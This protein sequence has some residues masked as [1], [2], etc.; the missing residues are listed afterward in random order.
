M[1]SENFASNVF[2]KVDPIGKILTLP[3]G[4]Y[5]GN[6]SDFIVRGVMK[7]FPQNSHFHPQFIT[8]PTDKTDLERGAW[9]YILL[10][11][12]ARPEQITN[13]FAKF[14]SRQVNKNPDEQQ[15]A[16]LEKIT[17]I[18][19]YSNKLREIE[20]N[21]SISVIYTLVIAAVLL[22]SIAIIN[23]INLN[24]GMTAF[25]D[26]YL[27]ISKILGGTDGTPMRYFFYE[28]TIIGAI[29]IAVS[30]L[31]IKLADVT[32]IEKFGLHLLDGKWFILLTGLL[33]FL[34]IIVLSGFLLSLRRDLLTFRLRVKDQQAGPKKGISMSLIVVQN[35]ISICLIVSVIVIHRQTDYALEHSVGAGDNNLI[36]FQNVHSEVQSK[37]ETFKSELLKNTSIKS[38]SA[39]LDAPGGETNDMMSFTMEGYISPSNHT[40]ENTIGVLPCDYSFAEI[41]SLSF[42]SGQNFS[43]KNDDS[44]GSGEY[45]INESAMKKL[46]Y[47]N[48]HDIVG[49]D[50]SISFS[51]S[52]KIPKGKIIAVVKDFHLSSLKKKIEPLVF[53]K[54]KDLWLLNFL[55][56]FQTGAQ[57]QGLLD[58][59][60]VLREV[61]PDQP[62]QYNY[63]SHL[64]HDVYKTELL[65]ANLLALFTIAALFISVMGLLGLSL[66]T[67]QRRMREIAIR[68]VNGASI[69]SLIIMLSWGFIKWIIVAF[70]LA[71]P[72]S[73]YAMNKWLEPF[74]YKTSVSWWI[75]ALASCV[76][77]IIA[78]V[79]IFIQ[80]YKATTTSPIEVLRND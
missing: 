44:E 63:V 77:V 6:N 14:Y 47:T 1:I 62:M 21:S 15:T 20:I 37:F 29:S 53:F 50:F 11:P 73:L 48:P 79:A 30:L 3:S 17:D 70:V 38:V 8:T 58:V 9:I 45:I 71:I 49:K 32:V 68:K 7:D 33:I 25:S 34:A 40:E 35:V 22:L 13:G 78:F 10:K 56:R 39:M 80:S 75:F 4:Q 59:A 5:Y 27:T 46:K 74:V 26:K 16:H 51:T 60:R 18:H 67:T 61:F 64:Y 65:E 19:L 57:S 52:I 76:S 31:I 72:I 23:F 12:N 42:L 55:I 36:C 2:G 24:I 66:L 69:Q 54:R 43:R 28:S 41:F